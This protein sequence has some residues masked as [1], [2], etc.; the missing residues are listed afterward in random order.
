[1]WTRRAAVVVICVLVLATWRGLD[2]QRSAQLRGLIDREIGLATDL[3]VRD[4]ASRFAAVSHFAHLWERGTP[5]GRAQFIADAQEQ[6]ASTPGLYAIAYA[7][8]GLILRDVAPPEL[9]ALAGRSIIDGEARRAAVE[10]ARATRRTVVSDPVAL[11]DGAGTGFMMYVPLFEGGAFRGTLIV[12]F[13]VERWLQSLTGRSTQSG[14]LPN[15]ALALSL[16]GRPLH[17]S[18]DFASTGTRHAA[19]AD[20]RWQEA[21]IRLEAR[22]RPAFYADHW[23]WTPEALALIVLLALSAMAALLSLLT[24]ARAAEARAHAAAAQLREVNATLRA[25]AEAETAR[26]ATSRFLATMSHE[27]RTPL[28]AIIGMFQLIE[29]AAAVPEKQRKQAGMGVEAARRLHRDLSNVLDISRL[30]AGALRVQV[31]ETDLAQLTHMWRAALEAYVMRAGKPIDC[32][33]RIDDDLP[34]RARLDATALTQVVNNLMDNAVKFTDTGRVALR[35]TASGDSLVIRVEDTGPGIAPERRETV[36]ERFY[37]VEDDTRRRISGTGLGLAISH[38]LV[39][40][41]HGSI[42]LRPATPRGSVFTV[43]LPGALIE[44]MAPPAV[45]LSDEGGALRI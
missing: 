33:V 43:T 14:F 7:D 34:A 8:A 2:L 1:M 26:A 18:A 32:A 25:E 5:P 41:M 10:R 16:N 17:E 44:N 40:L 22:P 21:T 6:M 31:E 29:A 13:H 36:F 11:M 45:L 39:S 23:F 38:D 27:I 37:R 24:R 28:N 3:L 12:A 42:T 4:L 30:D 15:H 19:T 20:G 35:V 9:Q